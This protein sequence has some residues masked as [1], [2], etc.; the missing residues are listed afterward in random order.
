MPKV[1]METLSSPLKIKKRAPWLQ[2]LA[3]AQ[4]LNK[5]QKLTHGQL[6]LIDGH[7]RHQFGRSH[8]IR[9]TITVNDAHF[10]GEVA[11]GGSI[12]AGEAYML[13][14]WQA[15]NLTHVIRLF[16]ANQSM[17]DTLEGGFEWLSKPILKTLHY[18]NRNTADGSRKN[19]AAHY[20]LGNDFFKLWLDPTMMYS[21]AIFAPSD[22]SLE[23]ASLKKLQVI[24]DKLDLKPSDHVL[25]IGTGWGGFAIYA[26]KNYGCQ[27][28]TTTISK[29]Q[30]DEAYARVK[31]E[32]LEHKIT[33]LLN[34]Y[35]DLKGQFDKLVSIEM[36][37]AVGHQFYDTYFKKVSQLLKPDG[38][39][40]IQAI[41]IA[42]QRF[43]AAKNSVDFIQR[44]IFPGSNIP[45]N[46]A[47]LN[48]MTKTT[49][50]R[51]FDL[52]DIGPYYATTLA[53]W[54]EN[55]FANIAQIRQLS[56]SEEFI[57]MWEFYLC[58]CEGGFAER[59]LGDVHLLL[60]KPENR[61]PAL[62]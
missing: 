17:M 26:A 27:V 13:G 4:V 58:Y 9:A 47:M 50:L 1:N 21:A 19:I 15:D 33:L 51:L 24:C 32:K 5:L 25:E 18:L 43:K 59:A 40:L 37:E 42:D 2:K 53:A 20:D 46:T 30:Y 12:G 62:I 52:E 45:S 34:D 35:R 23:A 61:R 55:F 7:E 60:A 10:Y 8:D 6:T 44:Y 22:C 28:T 14:Y 39:A 31:A 16:A 49:D 54:R 36:I 38:L 11:F 56:Y 29:Q 57:R 3:K 41:T 48:S